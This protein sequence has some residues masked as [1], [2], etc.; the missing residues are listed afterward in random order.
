MVVRLGLG[1]VIGGSSVVFLSGIGLAGGEGAGGEGGF[2]SFFFLPPITPSPP[3][4]FFGGDTGSGDLG[5]GLTSGDGGSGVGSAFG[6]VGVRFWRGGASG[7][8]SEA[9]LSPASRGGSGCGGL[10]AFLGDCFACFFGGDMGL[11]CF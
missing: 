9:V 10:D 3:L 2:S 8:E 7:S 6:G 4:F 11:C 1:G 5:A